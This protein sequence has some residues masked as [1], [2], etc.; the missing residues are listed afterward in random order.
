M[1]ALRFNPAKGTID[2]LFN[3]DG[4]LVDDE[5]R[6]LETAVLVSLH[7]NRRVEPSE[8]ARNVS[9]GGWWGDAYRPEGEPLEGSR[10]WLLTSADSSERDLVQRAQEYARN[11]LAW[12]LEDD[13]VESLEVVAERVRPD[14]IDLTVAAKVADGR[15]ALIR[16]ELAA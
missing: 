15:R 13:V 9:R 11:A 2:L 7:T 12:M 5:T 3:D 10:L 4:S 6:A 16:T 1:M 14:L 8:V